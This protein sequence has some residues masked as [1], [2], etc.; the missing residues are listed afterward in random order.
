MIHSYEAQREHCIF[1]ASVGAAAAVIAGAVVCEG[2]VGVFHVVSHQVSRYGAKVIRD[3]HGTT[4][5]T[6]RNYWIF[7]T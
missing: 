4:L 2:V 5:F 6:S 1:A 3:V 7:A